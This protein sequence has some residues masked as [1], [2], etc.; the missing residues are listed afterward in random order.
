MLGAVPPFDEPRDEVGCAQCFRTVDRRP[1]PIPTH[2][3]A[4]R[5]PVLVFVRRP[6]VSMA[7]SDDDEVPVDT[8]ASAQASERL[9]AAENMLR[10]GRCGIAIR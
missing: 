4:H 6:R 5:R 7:V 9:N 1:R 3:F 8:L 2:A 10:S